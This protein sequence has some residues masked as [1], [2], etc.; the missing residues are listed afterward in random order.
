M[1]KKK[2]TILILVGVILGSLGTIVN[3][4]DFGLKSKSDFDKQLFEL[5]KE[6]NKNL[7]KMIDSETRFDSSTAL[8]N[9]VFQYNY[10][11]V[12][13][14]KDELNLVEL[15]DQFYPTFLDNIKTNPNLKILRD[16]NVTI[17]F[18]IKDK[19]GYEILK[20][21]YDPNDYK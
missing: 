15:K 9:K 3:F 11:L 18:L 14:S 7:P 4:V 20:L 8:P 17:V 5:V 6:V 12:N 10:T 2:T 13:Y 19:D 1:D 21:M 16:N